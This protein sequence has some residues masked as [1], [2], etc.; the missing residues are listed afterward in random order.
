V[1]VSQTSTCLATSTASSG[2]TNTIATAMKAANSVHSA[3][4]SSVER[5]KD[6]TRSVR[7]GWWKARSGF[8]SGSPKR[9][10]NSSSG[11]G[12]V[13]GAWTSLPSPAASTSATA[14]VTT[15][16]MRASVVLS[17]SASSWS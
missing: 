17:D 5:P 6:A 16:A 7:P 3:T 12:A 11:D 2:V 10:S 14:L 1:T 15:W 8:D 4:V 9:S 13:T